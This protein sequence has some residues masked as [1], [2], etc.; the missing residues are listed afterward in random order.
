MDTKIL[1]ILLSLKEDVTEI[2]AEL[3]NRKQIDEETAKYLETDVRPWVE[4]Q[5]RLSWLSS[6]AFTIFISLG[7][8]MGAL[9]AIASVLK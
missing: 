4:S 6:R 8:L 3:K 1:E 7:S 2:K 9:T 5:K